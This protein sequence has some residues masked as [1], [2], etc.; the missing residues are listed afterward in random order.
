MNSNLHPITLVLHAW[1]LQNTQSKFSI[2]AF[3]GDK[4]LQASLAGGFNLLGYPEYAM[5]VP[6]LKLFSLKHFPGGN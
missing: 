5:N 3:V 6:F 4:I 1:V 2:Y